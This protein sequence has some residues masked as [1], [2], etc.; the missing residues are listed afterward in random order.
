MQA[1]MGP[2]AYLLHVS[3]L[4]IFDPSFDFLHIGADDAYVPPPPSC[5]PSLALSFSLTP[6]RALSSIVT[7]GRVEERA[8]MRMNL[9]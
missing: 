2:F 8:Q 6:A 4:A 5:P 9:E 7:L 3:G 1:E